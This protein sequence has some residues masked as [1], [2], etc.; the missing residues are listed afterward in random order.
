MNTASFDIQVSFLRVAERAILA[1]ERTIVLPEVACHQIATALR[2][3]LPIHVVDTATAVL[4]SLKASSEPISRVWLVFVTTPPNFRALATRF[5]AEGICLSATQMSGA[6]PRLLADV[7]RRASIA[8][9]ERL[10]LADELWHLA[11]LLPGDGCPAVDVIE[12]CAIQIADKSD[13]TPFKL[14]VIGGVGPAATVA[15]LDNIVQSTP[16]TRDQEHI[17]LVV[18]QN[19][20]IPDRTAHLLRNETDPTLALLYICERLQHAGATAIAIP[21]NTAHAFVNRIESQIDVPIVHMLRE[22]IA[23]I[24]REV[25][26]ARTIGLLATDGTIQSGLYHDE[27][28]AVGIDVLVPA[29]QHQKEI[30]TAIYGH[31]GVK[32]GH[33]E[34]DQREAVQRAIADLASR[35]ARAVILGCT[36]LPLLVGQDLRFECNGLMVAVIDP[37]RILAMRCVALSMEAS[38]ASSASDAAAIAARAGRLVGAVLQRMP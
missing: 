8:G 30:M 21:C 38:A 31:R 29:A 34:P 36:E 4:E 32:A 17:R 12:A 20:Q 22:T 6:E 33:R 9:V 11:G 5:A 2:P 3:A 35:G 19:P 27:A 15:F 37:S 26:D 16:A 18:E 13:H 25:P 23:F 14:G 7:A 24:V 28:C 10:W 1:G